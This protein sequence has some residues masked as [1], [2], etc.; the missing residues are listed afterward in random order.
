MELTL[1]TDRLLLR[2]VTLEDADISL[3]LLTDPEIMRY[4]GS[5]ISEREVVDNLPREVKRSG[6]GCIG[7]WTILETQT[8]E[9]IGSAL[10]LPLPIELDDT[11]WSLLGH[12]E[13]PEG[14]IEIGYMFKKSAWGKGYAS[15]AAGRLLR[16]AFE[17]TPLQEVVAVTDPE[18]T[19]SQRVLRKIGLRNEGMRRAYKYDCSAF[20]ITRSQWQSLASA[21]S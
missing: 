14:D 12:P 15:E 19:N 7:I 3:E 9:K 13:I 11:D 4:I 2:P 8:N 10:L 18:N 20:R 17:D 21:P 1:T 6:G 16:F 5:P